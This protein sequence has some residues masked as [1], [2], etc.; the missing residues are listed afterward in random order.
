MDSMRDAYQKKMEAQLSEWSA[1]IDVLKAKLDQKS[2][3]AELD[4]HRGVKELEELRA[5]ARLQLDAIAATSAEAW[6]DV[7]KRVEASWQK[8]TGAFDAFAKKV[9]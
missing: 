9:A 4:L 5:S 3:D 2:A 7:R 6:A 1:K 8:L